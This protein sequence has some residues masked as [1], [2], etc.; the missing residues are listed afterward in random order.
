MRYCMEC[1]TRLVYREL[2]GNISKRGGV[3]DM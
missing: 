3:F 1:G 2:E